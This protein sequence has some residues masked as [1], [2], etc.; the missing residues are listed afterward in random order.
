MAAAAPIPEVEKAFGRTRPNPSF[1][2]S[3]PI[4]QRFF[5]REYQYRYDPATNVIAF[6]VGHHTGLKRASVAL[7]DDP[8]F[9]IWKPR[10]ENR[11]A[12]HLTGRIPWDFATDCG[13]TGMERKAEKRAR[14][15]IEAFA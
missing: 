10:R 13:A 9:Y 4:Q 7:L 6:H 11:I 5:A 2:S 15:V 8:Y 1:I 14:Q 12:R 3:D